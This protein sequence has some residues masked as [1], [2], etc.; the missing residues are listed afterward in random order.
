M[1]SG[2]NVV[3]YSL[4]IEFNEKWVQGMGIEG[5]TEYLQAKI[6]LALGSHPHD[7]GQ[8]KKMRVVTP[9]AKKEG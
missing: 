5:L 3:K 9:R 6:A 2:N 7:R 4:T 8:L 1:S